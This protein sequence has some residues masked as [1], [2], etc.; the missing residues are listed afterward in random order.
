MFWTSLGKAMGKSFSAASDGS[1]VIRFPFRRYQPNPN[2]PA[3]A[4]V[5]IAA[6][7]HI[8]LNITQL[9][10]NEAERL[11]HF[12]L[13]QVDHSAVDYSYLIVKMIG[14]QADQRPHCV[15]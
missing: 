1:G 9:T 8:E 13:Q 6:R 11:C 14:Q 10:L 15:N 2:D 4:I 7:D 5:H 12:H 3:R